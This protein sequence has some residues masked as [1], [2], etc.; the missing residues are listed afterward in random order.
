V[1]IEIS[2][3]RTVPSI[4]VPFLS[5]MVTTSRVKRC[6][7]LTNFRDMV[8][9]RECETE[10]REGEKLEKTG[11]AEKREREREKI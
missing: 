7:N 8:E 4:T 3:P 5:S 6:K 2:T 1:F 9:E 11:R 10:E